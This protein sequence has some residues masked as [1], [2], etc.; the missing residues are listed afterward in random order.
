MNITQQK[1]L[2]TE[3]KCQLFF[4]EKGYNIYI[5]VSEDSRY[6]MIVDI[7]NILYRIQIKT[8]RETKN[9]TGIVFNTCSMRMNHTEGNI[10]VRYSEDEID[11]FMT[12]YNNQAY[13]IPISQCQGSEK[14]LSY[15]QNGNATLAFDYEAEKIIQCLI[16]D[17]EV[18]KTTSDNQKIIENFTNKHGVIKMDKDTK[19]PLAFYNSFTEAGIALG[20]EKKASHISQAARGQRKTAYGFAWS[21]I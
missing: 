2:A 9:K 21:K 20:D 18:I 6:D 3:L 12:Y 17:Q 4:I 1:G 10:K 7:N 11:F 16:E 8:G 15:R 13:L 5:P 14:T 19:E